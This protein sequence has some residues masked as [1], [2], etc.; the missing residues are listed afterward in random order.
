MLSTSGTLDAKMLIDSSISFTNSIGVIS[1]E[2]LFGINVKSYT[3]YY[4]SNNVFTVS[5]YADSIVNFFLAEFTMNLLD[6]SPVISPKA[7]INS[8]VST[9]SFITILNLAG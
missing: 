4:F 5:S 8:S 2:V 6:Y 9:S 7:L 1:Q 3:V